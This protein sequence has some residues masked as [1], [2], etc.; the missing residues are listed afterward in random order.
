MARI[1]P[2]LSSVR[3]RPVR[4]HS[5]S[6]VLAL[7]QLHTQRLELQAAFPTLAAEHALHGA[8]DR[9]LHRRPAE[10]DIEHAAVDAAREDGTLI[11]KKPAEIVENGFAERLEKTGFLKGLWNH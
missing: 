3:Q 9:H 6:S 1:G 10:V 11:R 7:Q 2:W 5:W 8:G 4:R